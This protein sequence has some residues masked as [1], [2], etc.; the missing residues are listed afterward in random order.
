MLDELF[1]LLRIATGALIYFA[2]QGLFEYL[3][4]GAAVSLIYDKEKI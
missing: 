3:V 1:A 2:T 4:Y